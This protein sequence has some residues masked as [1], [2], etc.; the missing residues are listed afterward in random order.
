MSDFETDLHSI[1]YIVHNSNSK[2]EA[3]RRFQNMH[4]FSIKRDQAQK[5][6]NHALGEKFSKEKTIASFISRVT[7]ALKGKR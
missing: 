1:R 3:I 7:H 6:F 4:G 2:E 5:A